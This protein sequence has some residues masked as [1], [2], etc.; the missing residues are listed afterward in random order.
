MRGGRYDSS[1]MGTA[2]YD[3]SKG[4]FGGNA[5]GIFPTTDQDPDTGDSETVRLET[6]MKCEERYLR[7]LSTPTPRNY[8]EEMVDM[9]EK[10]VMWQFPIDNE[11]G[12]DQ[13]EVSEGEGNINRG[14]SI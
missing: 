2:V 13:D 4:I 9:T 1:E 14:T 11:Q 3:K 10:G 6:W 12:I 8:L 5:L 7:L